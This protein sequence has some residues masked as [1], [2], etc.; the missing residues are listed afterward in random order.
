MPIR[1]WQD[2]SLFHPVHLDDNARDEVS[3]GWNSF[4]GRPKAASAKVSQYE[5][6]WGRNGELDA[7]VDWDFLR[8]DSTASRSAIFIAT[9]APGEVMPFCLPDSRRDR[10]LRIDLGKPWNLSASVSADTPGAHA[11]RISPAVDLQSMPHVSTRSSPLF[12]VAVSP[13]GNSAFDG[14]LGIWFETEMGSGHQ[15]IVKAVKKG[16]FAFDHT[17]VHV[18]DELL[19]VDGTPVSP[20]SFVDTMKLLKKRL[21]EISSIRQERSNSIVKDVSS[22]SLLGAIE[23]Y[24][25]DRALVITFRSVEE[26]LRLVRLKAARSS[27]LPRKRRHLTSPDGSTSG[28]SGSR[29][30]TEFEGDIH[31]RLEL[32][33][34]ERSDVGMFLAVKK[35]SSIPFRLRNQSVDSIVCYRQKNCN[36]HPWRFLQPGHS[37]SYTWEEPMKPKR[38]SVRVVVTGAGRNE[39]SHGTLRDEEETIFTSPISVRLEEVGFEELIPLPNQKSKREFLRL[40]VDVEESSRILLIADGSSVDECNQIFDERI[41]SLNSEIMHERNRLET[42]RSLLEDGDALNIDSS[43]TS[44]VVD[45]ANSRQ[46]GHQITSCHQLVVIVQEARGLNSGSLVGDCNP[47]VEVRLKGCKDRRRNLFE[48]NSTMR[49]V[50]TKNTPNP[51]WRDQVFVFDVTPDAVKTTRGCAVSVKVKSFGV[52]RRHVVLGRTQID[53][54]CLRDEIPKEGWFPLSGRNGRQELENDHS[55]WGR[56]SVKLRIQWIHTPLALHRYFVHISEE[57]LWS[58]QQK[59][60]RIERQVQFIEMRK[61]QREDADNVQPLRFQELFSMSKNNTKARAAQMLRNRKS[62]QHVVKKLID[63]LRSSVLKTGRDR[64]GIGTDPQPE[65]TNVSLL[66]TTKFHLTVSPPTDLSKRKRLASSGLLPEL[67]DQIIETRQ[68]IQRFNPSRPRFE[69]SQTFESDYIKLP[70]GAF[71]SWATVHA[72]RAHSR[73]ELSVLDG[74]IK[75]GLRDESSVSAHSKRSYESGNTVISKALL[76]PFGSPSCLIDLAKATSSSFTEA[77]TS[78][79][80]AARMT[81]QTILNPGGWLTIRP[82]TAINLPEGFSHLFVKVK[83]GSEVLTTASASSPTSPVWSPLSS[84]DT[85]NDIHIHVAPQKTSGSIRISV[86]GEKRNQKIRSRTELGVLFLPLGASIAACV[87]ETTEENLAA[88]YVRWY[89]LKNPKD[90]SQSE[91]DA[92]LSTKPSETEKSDYRKLESDFA[93]CLKLTLLW[94]PGSEEDTKRHD[95]TTHSS[96]RIPSIRNYFT[97]E[98]NSISLALIDSDRAKEVL[99]LNLLDLDLHY[100]ATRTKTRFGMTAG[101]IQA[102]YQDDDTREPVVL[103]PSQSDQLVPVLQFLAVKDNSKSMRGVAALDFVDVQLAEFDVT[104]EENL[105]FDLFSLLK[106]VFGETDIDNDGIRSVTAFDQLANQKTEDFY[107]YLTDNADGSQETNMKLYIKHFFLGVLRVNFSYVKGRRS[108]GEILTNDQILPHQKVDDNENF[109]SDALLGWRYN[110]QLRSDDYGGG[111]YIAVFPTDLTFSIFFNSQAV[112]V[113]SCFSD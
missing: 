108:N 47:Y 89:P 60:D 76:P 27:N 36:H 26:R 14:S 97:A 86:V 72:V 106:S 69:S 101:W 103:S 96:L 99:S 75:I 105:I 5:C 49:S 81:L 91:G 57:K 10:Q 100:W 70:P 56:G 74:E 54:H 78:A 29:S 43:W 67:E 82:Q 24:S 62:T 59:K 15:I 21:S 41:N 102:D 42:L 64:A 25:D 7:V 87:S 113:S 2:S 44:R 16:S 35:E 68:A 71:K 6:L 33:T 66:P 4:R 51:H 8:E 92:G 104:I 17:D 80:Q 65:P 52:L 95:A 39:R 22:S 84:G 79:H 53:L 30:R 28:H 45:V 46:H 63:P 19:A 11:L 23:G 12:E 37:T 77:R 112:K 50:Y 55:D 83:Y 107:E 9:L 61:R 109:S 90:M 58:L 38:L 40:S 110:E 85:R 93:P 13:S 111:R 32:R 31:I 1:I 20:L 34:V 18:G 88:K 94:S 48:R 3:S 98:F 73:L